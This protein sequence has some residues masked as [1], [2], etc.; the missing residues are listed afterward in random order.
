MRSTAALVH[1]EVA[2]AKLARR[3]HRLSHQP[4]RSVLEVPGSIAHPHYLRRRG[5]SSM[6][7]PL[8]NSSA[9]T[10]VRK[11]LQ[12]RSLASGNISVC[13]PDLGYASVTA[14]F[15][16]ILGVVPRSTTLRR[17]ILLLDRYIVGKSLRAAVPAAGPLGAH[18]VTLRPPPE[19]P[20]LFH[21]PKKPHDTPPVVTD[22]RMLISP[23]IR[24]G[25][26][27]LPPL[28]YTFRY[29]ITDLVTRLPLSAAARTPF[30]SRRSGSAR[31][32]SSGSSGVHPFTTLCRPPIPRR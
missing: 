17:S 6:A 3:P 29:H 5:L 9:E 21:G 1:V 22:M 2:T 13:H 15:R 25:R 19:R 11:H 32:L 7:T 31:K 23:S 28:E 4:Q 27:A 8:P 30:S 12:H 14:L 26:C 20:C 24:C 10:W 18:A 16:L